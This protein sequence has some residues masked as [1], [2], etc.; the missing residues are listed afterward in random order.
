MNELETQIE[1]AYDFRGHVTLKLKKGEAVEGF[2][3]NRQLGDAKLKEP[4]YVEV[5]IKGS[6]DKRKIAV[7]ELESIA[8]TG[9]D[10][11]AGKSY[12]DYQKKKAAEQQ[13]KG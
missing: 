1:K 2:I 4:P 6:G 5:M 8:M 12:D 3:F 9:E 10:C 11:A 7:A 13:K